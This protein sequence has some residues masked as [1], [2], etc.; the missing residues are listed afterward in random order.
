ML[1]DANTSS[2][3][4]W[5]DAH[6]SGPHTAGDGDPLEDELNVIMP[7]CSESLIVIDDMQNAELKHLNVDFTGWHREYRTGEVIMYRDGVYKIPEFELD[8][9]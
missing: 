1:D 5:L 4:F 3:L 2:I 8:N 6:C 9:G 7:R